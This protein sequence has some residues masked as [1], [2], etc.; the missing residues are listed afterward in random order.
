[1]HASCESLISLERTVT[2]RSTTTVANLL[3]RLPPNPSQPHIRF[4]SIVV[5][6]IW[7]ESQIKLGVLY[8]L[9]RSINHSA[10]DGSVRRPADDLKLNHSSPNAERL[11]FDSHEQKQCE[12]NGRDMKQMFLWIFIW[13]RFDIGVRDAS[14][15]SGCPPFLNDNIQ[16]VPFARHL[17]HFSD[18]SFSHL[19][20]IRLLLI[21]LLFTCLLL[22]F[23]VRQSAVCR[24]LSK[25][26]LWFYRF[27]LHKDCRRLWRCNCVSVQW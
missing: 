11:V 14:T 8:W 26:K 7:S 17:F 4:D 6:Q 18:Q 25:E 5:R 15:L 3:I 21:W 27:R 24:P 12:R 13:K 23:T 9:I 2:T 16:F 22:C 19:I 10:L 20:F 1:M